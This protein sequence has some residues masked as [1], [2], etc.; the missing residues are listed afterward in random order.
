VISGDRLPTLAAGR[1]TLRWLTPAD[2][3]ALFEIFSDPEVMR[4]WS[5]GPY[6]DEGQ[7]RA[8]LS[9]I[10]SCFRAKSLF[11]WGVARAPEDRIVGT[12]TLSEVDASNLRAQVGYA[13]AKAHWG[14]GLMGQ[15][16]ERLLAFAFDDLRLRRLEADVDPEN[17]ASIRVLERLGFQKEGFLR[18]RWFVG[19]KVQDS[20]F[21]GLLRREW[22][23]RRV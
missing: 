3:P 16:L 22:D 7:A 8:L 14:Q 2:V 19:G 17:R 4:Y 20:L 15:A 12:C 23:A 13:L 18:E 10:E 6:A 21:Y 5:C 1:V 9:S 11:Q